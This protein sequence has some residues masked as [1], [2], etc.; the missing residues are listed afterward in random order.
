MQGVV[1]KIICTHQF[2]I[3]FQISTHNVP[4]GSGVNRYARG[5]YVRVVGMGGSFGRCIAD[6]YNCPS[7]FLIFKFINKKISRSQIKYGITRSN[8]LL[9]GFEFF[10]LFGV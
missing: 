9:Y 5:L 8:R 3:N 10:L 6:E 1:F 7:I 4:S 2:F